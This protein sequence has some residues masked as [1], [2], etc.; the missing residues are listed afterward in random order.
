MNLIVSDQTYRPKPGT[1]L[2]TLLSGQNKH[3]LDTNGRIFGFFS[4]HG[5]DLGMAIDTT[6][7]PDSNWP[8][9][10]PHTQLL[11]GQSATIPNIDTVE[12]FRSTINLNTLLVVVPIGW[13]W[14]E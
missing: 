3:L 8:N 9:G 5:D 13:S 7:D 1:I 11:P 4:F 6:T 12:L 2:L 14:R 10:F